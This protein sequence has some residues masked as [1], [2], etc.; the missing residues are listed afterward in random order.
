M[1]TKLRSSRFHCMMI[2]NQHVSRRF[3]GDIEGYIVSNKLP[4]AFSGRARLF[5]WFIL[6]GGLATFGFA[7]TSELQGSGRRSNEPPVPARGKLG[8]DLFIAIDHRDTN[9]VRELLKQ[10]A[11]P[12]SLN[13]LEFRPLYIAAASYQMDVML[14][15]LEAGANPDAKSTYGTPLS[16]A[17]ISGNVV[18]AKMLLEKGANPNTIRSDGI[19]VLMA[20]SKAGNPALVEELLKHKA[21]VNVKDDGG[22]SA[23]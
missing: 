18:G 21:D 23:L 9:A 8:Q 14:A 1:T 7:M 19:S 22:E 12:N 3:L 11:D 15:L 10:G 5:S 13:G 16:F 2:L 4:L 17:A 6:I 20:A